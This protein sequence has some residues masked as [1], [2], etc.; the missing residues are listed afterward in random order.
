MTKF[1][2]SKSHFPQNSHFQSLIFHKIHI[3]Q[4][5]FFT[6][7][8]FL[9]S[10][11]YKIHIFEI[12]K[13]REFLDKKWVFAPVWRLG[14]HFLIKTMKWY[15]AD[16]DASRMR[17]GLSHQTLTLMEKTCAMLNSGGARARGDSSETEEQ[18]RQRCK[19]ILKSWVYSILSLFYVVVNICTITQ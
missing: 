6:K 2:F 4:I 16:V 11:L 1:T 3:S 17:M 10:Q 15:F 14:E 8:T 7:F 12:S 13:S 5:S 19:A 18:F 9:K